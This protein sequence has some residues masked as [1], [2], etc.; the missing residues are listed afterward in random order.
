MTHKTISSL[1][2]LS[3]LALMGCNTDL[4]I[5]APTGSS[6]LAVADDVGALYALN[7]GLG[8]ISRV[9]L[10]TGDVEETQLGETPFRVARLDGERVAVSLRSERA[11]VILTDDGTGLTVTDRLQVGA[12]PAG[13]VSDG[14]G[15]LFVALATQGEIW[16]FSAAGEHVNTFEV[17]GQPNWLALRPQGD[18]LYAASAYGATVTSI[19]LATGETETI[20]MPVMEGLE[21]D[22]VDTPVT[23]TARI[24]GDPSISPDGETMAVPVTYLDNVTPTDPDGDDVPEPES[25]YSSGAGSVGVTRINPTLVTLGTVDGGLDEG[26]TFFLAGQVTSNQRSSEV[27]RGY[28][29]SATWHPDGTF[30]WITM[31]GS[32]IV[33]ALLPV[34]RQVTTDY[35]DDATVTNGEMV[36]GDRA[37]FATDAGP[38]GVAFTVDG[39]AYVHSFLDR[40]IAL[41]GDEATVEVSGAVLSESTLPDSIEEGRK[42]FY[43][44]T[45][46]IMSA[47]GSGM[48]CATCHLQGRNDGLTW[49][50]EQGLR[51][52]PSLA[53][54]VGHTAPFTWID[55]V[56]SVAD[57]AMH[58]SEVRMG[59]AGLTQAE[60][61]AIASFVDFTPLPDTPDV[62]DSDA[63][64]RGAEI[65]FSAEVGCG[66]C[67]YGDDYTDHDSHDMFGLEGVNTPRLKGVAASAPY[68]HDGSAATLRDVLD[69][70]KDGE[71]GDTS[72]LSDEQM[73]D[74]EAF[75]RTL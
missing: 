31:E 13:L 37:I 60:A 34:A 20:E 50:L 27:V 19:D 8:S 73:D 61:D 54:E 69:A 49:N 46:A 68:L 71:M 65:F 64:S 38:R 16:E 14:A 18:V 23:L 44:S 40:Q 1:S 12:D 39:E 4:G 6:S 29:S 47:D 70:V 21:G 3:V 17:E 28:V 45:G 75:L 2:L 72:S 11:I 26:D 24:T 15:R 30:L 59:G 32:N 62:S 55:G 9:D 41:L 56:D 48:S 25:S 7:E 53:G 35:H 58:T 66:S 74:L 63:V 22:H 42:L 67:H 51:Q 33:Q 43:A 36:S 52:T 10:A 5:D 57:E